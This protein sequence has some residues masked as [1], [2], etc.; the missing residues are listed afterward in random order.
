MSKNIQLSLLL[1]A[2]LSQLH[3]VETIILKPLSITSTAIKTDELS[4]T[5]AIDVYT[6]KD[7][8]KAHVQNLYEFLNTQT[9]VISM[10]SYGNPF[11]QKLDMRGY[12]ISDGYQ[13]IIVTING[14][15][16]NNIDLVAPLLSAISPSSISKIE[17][18]KSSGIVTGGDGA[19]A[20]VINITTKHNN[21]KEISL[22]AGSYGARAGTL[23]LGHSADDISLSFSGELQKNNGIRH[24]AN[25][26][27]K[28]ENSLKATNFTLSY[29]P[30]DSLEL[31]AGLSYSDTDVIYAGKLTLDEYNNDIT[32]AGSSSASRQS[33]NTRAYNLG[34]SYDISS[35]LRLNFDANHE[36]KTSFYDY[37]ASSYES[38][39]KY[40]YNSAKTTLEYD[41]D[42]TSL[43][44]GIDG[45]YGNREGSSKETKKNNLA[46]FVMAKFNSD[47]HSLKIG[48]RYEKV[49]YIY[50]DSTKLNKDNHSL[51]GG[52]LGYNYTFDK[53][54]SLFV[55]YAH[56]YQAPD[57]DRFFSSGNFNGFINPMKTDS[58]TLG[59]NHITPKNK[60]KISLY[61]VNLED[62]I[63][64]HKTGLYTG[65][66]TNIDESHKYGLDIYNKFLISNKF[67]IALN[68]NYVKAM[69]DKEIDNGDDYSNKE[70]PG[71]S[72]HNIKAT[73]SYIPI[74]NTTL[75]LTQVYR[76]ETYAANDFANNF[77]Q[78]QDAYKTTDISF[79]YIKDTYEFFAKINNIFNQKNGIWIKNDNIYPVNF[80]T[81]AIAGIKA[82]F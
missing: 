3:A 39:S 28:D 9:S 50:Q 49:S 14:R 37:L 48:S 54:R 10:P 74:T 42:S 34:T 64:Y 2:L 73:L 63:Y 22:H 60:L 23:Y 75:N 17:I 30:T 7:I 46:T 45:F 26:A 76:S 18:I 62:E 12:G 35:N 70:L 77:S 6:Q 24:I 27:H 11:S 1:V 19:N 51:Y 69:I 38:T 61:Y 57:I 21:D 52:E 47:K 71:V 56:A 80:T 40:K 8:E 31:R 15:K 4:S 36:N 68:Y 32:Q 67:N 79:T 13:N 55:N 20:G 72:N 25:K 53:E 58:L 81:T 59:Y 29:T 78:K 41:N 33:Y 16:I 43:I 44:F 65:V 82:R 66:N 5:D